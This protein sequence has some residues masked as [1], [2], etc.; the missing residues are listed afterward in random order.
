[1]LSFYEYLSLADEEYF[2]YPEILEPYK[3]LKIPNNASKQMTKSAF[4]RN[5]ANTN[6]SSTCL[7]YEMICSKEKFTKIGEEPK[8]KVKNKDQFYYVH[9]GYLEGLKKFVDHDPSLINKKDHMGRSLL[10]L[11]ARNGYIDICFYLLQKGANINDTQG[12]G[13]TPLH[14]AS[15][16]GNDLVVQLLL[17]YGADTKIKN[18]FSHYAF[19]ESKNTSISK[20]I[21]DFR[22]DVINILLTKL[23]KNNLSH[24]MRLLKK[25]GKVV[26]KKILRNISNVYNDWILCWH[27]THYNAL[28]SIMENGLIAAGTKLKNGIEL[29][30]KDNHISRYKPVN[31][32]EDWAKAIFVSPS[33]LYA[34]DTCYSERIYSEGEKWGILIETKVRPNSYFARGS[35]VKRY[36]LCQ[37]EPKNVEYRIPSAEDVAVTSIVFARCSYIDNNKNYLNLT[38]SFKDF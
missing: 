37:N 7:A 24:G 34:L 5:L 26:G 16:Y 15:F 21:K 12:S 18:N 14:G 22:N 27:G 20:N 19:D 1:M 4:R 31:E 30:P 6:R 17:Q 36:K 38:S 10:Y 8:Y 11:A 13:S 23:D 28:E 32:I 9:V 2:D 3:V 29:E 35:T 25:Q 33:I